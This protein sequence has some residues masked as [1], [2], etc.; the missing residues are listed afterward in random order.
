MKNRLAGWLKDK[1][2]D[3]IYFNWLLV[4]ESVVSVVFFTNGVVF[5]VE[6]VRNDNDYDDGDEAPP[7]RKSSKLFVV[8]KY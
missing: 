8:M 7:E 6:I 3:N 1:R 4:H 2:S 5:G